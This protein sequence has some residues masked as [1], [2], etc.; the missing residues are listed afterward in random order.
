MYS[1][2]V[3]EYFENPI[4]MGI[5]EDADGTGITENEICSDVI[6]IYIKVNEKNIIENAKFEAKGCPPVIA[7]CC[8]VTNIIK[9]MNIDESKNITAKEIIEKLS[10]LPKEKEHCAELVVKTLEKAILNIKKNL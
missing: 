1:K 4:N 9:N 5:I 2:E 6:K 10:G 8:A 7:A 3:K